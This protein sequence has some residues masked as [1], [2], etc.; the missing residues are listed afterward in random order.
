MLLIECCNRK[1]ACFFVLEFK[2]FVTSTRRDS[3]S[4]FFN[5][6]LAG[7][8]RKLAISYFEVLLTSKGNPRPLDSTDLLNA[9]ELDIKV[10]RGILLSQRGGKRGLTLDAAKTKEAR[11][12]S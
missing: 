3:L 6:G 8:L 9:Q 1:A 4:I 2:H 10:E 5:V 7:K 11:R 12:A